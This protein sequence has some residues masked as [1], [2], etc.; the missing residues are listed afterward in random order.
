VELVDRLLEG[1]KGVALLARHVEVE[2]FRLEE[3]KKTEYLL[4]GGAEDVVGAHELV[5]QHYI[6]NPVFF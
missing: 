2:V 5:G 6:H 1:E 4:H 3:G